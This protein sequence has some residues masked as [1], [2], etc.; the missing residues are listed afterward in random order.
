MAGLSLLS[1]FPPVQNARQGTTKNRATVVQEGISALIEVLS[2]T[3][4]SMADSNPKRKRVEGVPLAG[5]SG[6]LV[7]NA[8][9]KADDFAATF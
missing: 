1:L 6:Y 4:G 8:P 5:P 7:R 3:P 9:I 2:K